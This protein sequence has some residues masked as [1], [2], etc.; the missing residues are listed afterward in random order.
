MKKTAWSLQK[1]SVACS[2]LDRQHGSAYLERAGH[3]PQIQQ[4]YWKAPGVAKLAR[5][6]QLFK[7]FANEGHDGAGN[8]ASQQIQ[9]KLLHRHLLSGGVPA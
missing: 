3:L 4:K 8:Y 2:L 7:A 6:L 9:Q 1:E 5:G